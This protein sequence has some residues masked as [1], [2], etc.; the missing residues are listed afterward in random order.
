MR[1]EL[2]IYAFCK[3]C[4]KN[5]NLYRHFPIIVNF[6]E[7]SGRIELDNKAKLAVC[8]R[9]GGSNF[10]AFLFPRKGRSE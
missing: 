4:R 10:K 8:D 5:E 2:T 9:C 3:D 7:P 1:L 6:H